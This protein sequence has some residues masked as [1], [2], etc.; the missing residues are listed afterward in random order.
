MVG[1]RP[2][3]PAAP[4]PP[5]DGAARP[6]RATLPPAL[7]GTLWMLAGMSAIG[8]VDGLAKWLARDLHGVQVAWGYFL[9]MLVCL[10]PVAAARRTSPARLLRSYR[11]WL[12]LARAGC[13]VMSLSC[14]FFSLR[15]LP[16][17]EA[18]TIGFTAPLFIVALS[19]PMLGER[20]GRARWAAVLAG[21]LGALIV[22]R[23]GTGLLHWSSMVA[24]TGAFFFAQFNIVTRK[25]GATDRPLTTLFH[26]FGIGTLILS[27]AVPVVWI[28]P[29]AAQWLVFAVSG[30]LGLLGHYAIFRSLALADASVVAPLNYVR[31]VW[32]VAIGVVIFGDVPDAWTLTGGAI[33]VASGLYVVLRSRRRGRAA[34]A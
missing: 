24:L 7:A 32:A 14:L 15:W 23:P 4:P 18:T 2:P 10:L 5:A 12:Q 26:T 21:M 29:T 28:T 17:A 11:P 1:T 31:L 19:G 30:T 25:L 6:S 33:T 27:A 13:L 8:L 34:V 22:A 20:V 3:R 9:V 16:L